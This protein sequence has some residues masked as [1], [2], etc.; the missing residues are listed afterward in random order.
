MSNL[1]EDIEDSIIERVK[2]RVPLPQLINWL[3]AR[4]LRRYV[5]PLFEIAEPAEM[6]KLVQGYLKK[7][8]DEGI[9][10]ELEKGET[11]FI[12]Y[13][14]NLIKKDLNAEQSAT[15]KVYERINHLK[16]E[17]K[18]II[19][20]L[21]TLTVK[22]K[23]LLSEDEFRRLKKDVNETY[24]KIF[25]GIYLVMDNI[26]KQDLMVARNRD[27][28]RAM[29]WAFESSQ[30]TE[31]AFFIDHIKVDDKKE[32]RLEKDIENEFSPKTIKK[33]GE[34]K[35]EEI[36]VKDLADLKKII[37]AEMEE[38]YKYVRILIHI[39]LDIED[40]IKKLEKDYIGKNLGELKKLPEIQQQ[41][42]KAALDKLIE[43]A[44]ARA[45]EKE[46]ERDK[47]IMGDAHSG[48][49]ESG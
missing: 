23:H 45:E 48:E 37:D 34:K 10:E 24:G 47:A 30:K 16:K 19:A 1:L 22:D 21:K 3:A 25:H 38:I 18:S 28:L 12:K 46:T 4:R 8:E 29:F 44:I 6:Q 31:L 35:V 41:K 5:D 32:E 7:G 43:D 27:Q 40:G 13:V 39:I 17:R 42:L 11:D 15:W 9:V 36:I 33:Q 2:L 20:K 26:R 14:K 49:N